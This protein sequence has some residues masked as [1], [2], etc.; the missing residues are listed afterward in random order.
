[1][2]KVSSL[3]D[4][5]CK[6]GRSI[7]EKVTTHPA[8]NP[9]APGFGCPWVWDELCTIRAFVISELSGPGILSFNNRLRLLWGADG[10]SGIQ[11]GGVARSLNRFKEYTKTLIFVNTAVWKC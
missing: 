11:K 10:F 9:R 6:A 5:T 1:M 2:S 7:A 3:D 4:V 8:T